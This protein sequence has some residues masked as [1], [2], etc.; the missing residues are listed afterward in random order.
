MCNF[1]PN[2]GDSGGPLVVNDGGRWTLVGITSAGF[3]CAVDHQ[4]GIYHKVSKTVPWI[5][6]NINDWTVED[7]CGKQCLGRRGSWTRV[8]NLQCFHWSHVIYPPTAAPITNN[9]LRV[10][11][12]FPLSPPFSSILLSIA[13]KTMF[14]FIYLLIG[15]PIIKWNIWGV[16]WRKKIQIA[17]WR[18]WQHPPKHHEKNF[19]K[20]MNRVMIISSCASRLEHNPS[21]AVR[22]S[23]TYQ[24]PLGHQDHQDWQICSF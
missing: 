23:H 21:L 17:W 1:P 20:I 3:G 19:K 6:A 12:V 24:R 9:I 11:C 14:F 10:F 2:Q 22:R 18:R 7:I 15:T 13:C 4:P 8:S 5:L 16:Y